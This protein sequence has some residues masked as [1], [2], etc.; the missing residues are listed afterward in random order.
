M[1]VRKERIVKS[2]PRAGPGRKAK[3]RRKTRKAAAPPPLGTQA[4]AGS[5]E[6][7]IGSFPLARGVQL[8]EL[9][10]A[11]A[12]TGG[13]QVGREG[14]G[15]GVVVPDDG[16]VVPAGV[17]DAVLDLRELFLQF[18]ETFVRL[19]VRV[20]FRD[21]EQGRELFPEGALF[22]TSFAG[23]FGPHR[24]GPCLRDTEEGLLLVAGIPLDGLHQVSHE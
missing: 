6:P 16:V 4:T 20:A 22:L 7:D 10:P 8:E 2:S 9:R 3:T 15:R 24:T 5:G 11:E 14:L 13:D 1:S 23:T 19:E 21:R 18:E 12:E 17:L